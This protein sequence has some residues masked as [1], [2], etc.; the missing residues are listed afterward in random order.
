MITPL[1]YTFVPVAAWGDEHD[2]FKELAS[3]VGSSDTPLLVTGVPI[4]NSETYPVNP[5]LSARYGL[6]GL[7][8]KDFPRFKLFT[9]GADT[10]KPID[11]KGNTKNSKDMLRWI[12]EQTGVFVGI[13]GQVKELD[14]LAKQFMTASA[15]DRAQLLKQAQAAGDAVDTSSNPDAASFVEYYIKTMQR[16]LDKGDSYAEQETKRL[17]KMSDDKG[18]AAA[19]KETFQWRLNILAS[20]T[21]KADKTEL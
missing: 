12:V 2:A 18:V 13:K 17:S 10:T 15:A 3:T 9:K 11:Y 21:N 4:S 14:T 8:D 16:V 20:F 6:A 1:L 7:Q 19:K 5:K